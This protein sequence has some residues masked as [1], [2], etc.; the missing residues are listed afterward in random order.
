MV[1]GILVSKPIIRLLRF[2]D[3]III[4]TR[5]ISVNNISILDNYMCVYCYW[6]NENYHIYSNRY[7]N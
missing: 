7:E 2:H 1:L 5:L 6:N 3:D 4:A